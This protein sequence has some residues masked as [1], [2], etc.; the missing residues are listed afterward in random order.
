MTTDGLF[1][2]QE[3]RTL[4]QKISPQIAMQYKPTASRHAPGSQLPFSLNP[5]HKRKGTMHQLF[6][7][8]RM[9]LISHFHIRLNSALYFTKIGRKCQRSYRILDTG[10][11]TR[12][13]DPR[14]ILPIS[15]GSNN[16]I[17]GKKLN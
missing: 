7:L 16:S 15:M 14:R 8:W 4:L 11:G 3:I 17:E 12:I 6:V 9:A 5:D 13:Q 2:M 10:S 1:F